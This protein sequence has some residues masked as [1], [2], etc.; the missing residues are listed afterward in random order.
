MTNPWTRILIGG[1]LL[2][3]GLLC[4]AGAV[5]NMRLFYS[6]HSTGG[7]ARVHIPGGIAPLL[8]LLGVPLLIAGSAFAAKG[9]KQYLRD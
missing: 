6:F 3:A 8:I 4:F 9:I 1:A 2:A 7:T 5:A